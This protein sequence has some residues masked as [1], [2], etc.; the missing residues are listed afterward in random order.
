VGASLLAMAFSAT[1]QISLPIH[2]P[3]LPIHHCN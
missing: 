2:S 1:P 3:F